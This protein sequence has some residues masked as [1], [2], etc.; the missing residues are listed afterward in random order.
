[1]TAIQRQQKDTFYLSLIYLKKK[2][3]EKTCQCIFS[4]HLNTL[5]Q[6]AA[7]AVKHLDILH[8]FSIKKINLNLK[9]LK[10]QL[11]FLTNFKAAPPQKKEQ[12]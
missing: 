3:V 10:F 6:T 5:N 7:A 11:N 4:P 12:Q 8:N 1:M 9:K 2:E